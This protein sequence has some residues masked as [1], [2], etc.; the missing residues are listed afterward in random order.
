MDTA[1]TG[2][3][4]RSF[5]GTWDV[6][7]PS[8]AQRTVILLLV[9]FLLFF[10][11]GGIKL[12]G[13]PLT[14]GY[15]VLA[16]VSISLPLALLLGRSWKVT[17]Q[18]LLLALLLVPFQAVVWLSF[19]FNGVVGMGFTISLLVSF[20][21]VP[22]VFLLVLGP[23]LD[24]LDLSY[25][26]RLIRVG[27][28]FVA[29]Y[30]I[31]L[32]FFKLATGTFIEIPLLTVNSGDLGELDDK[33][34]DRGG[35]FKLISTYNNGNIYGVCLLMLLPLFAWLERRMI[36]NAIVKFSLLLTL[37][38]TVWLGLLAFELLNRLYVRPLTG[39]ALG[40]LVGSVVVVIGG[41]LAALR[42]MG[43]DPAFLFDRNLGGRIVQ[44][45]VLD[46]A[47]ILP[48]VSFEHIL[49]MVYLSVLENFGLVGLVTF[50]IAM[51]TPLALHLLRAVPHAASEYKRCLAAGLMVYLFI[52]LSDGALLFIPVMAFFWF[53]VSLLVSPNPS[54][55]GIEA[56]R[57]RKPGRA[58]L[59]KAPAAASSRGEPDLVTA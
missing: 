29:A 48:R 18:R 49:E 33:Y 56:R 41:V 10:P 24:R 50:L 25:L 17:R 20:F 58:L 9:G 30:G 35:I 8:R 5:R 52:A 6:V 12:A 26:F 55:A 14:W 1:P 47:T 27:V 40:L 3:A 19:M 34:I 46:E 53:V 21:F 38:R 2:E 32:F 4:A 37:S 45:E 57:A 13:V 36:P 59:R 23:Q 54:F 11:K 31:F 15:I 44:L 22:H 16:A 42:L 51:V 39:R 28:L 7:A 43:M